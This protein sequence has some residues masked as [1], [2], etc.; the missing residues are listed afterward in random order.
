MKIYFNFTTEGVINN[1]LQPRK[2]L[3]TNSTI[4]PLLRQSPVSPS[5]LPRTPEPLIKG[6]SNSI[7]KYIAE[8]LLLFFPFNPV[9]IEISLL[10]TGNSTPSVRR[11]ALSSGASG[12]RR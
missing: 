11:T 9:K 10:R 1:D 7:A 12:D 8:F 4:S 3:S 2:P 5:V 6:N